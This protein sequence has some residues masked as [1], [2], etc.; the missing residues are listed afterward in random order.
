MQC[1]LPS[2]HDA[3]DNHYIF[4]MYLT[5]FILYQHLI[6]DLTLKFIFLPICNLKVICFKYSQN[7]NEFF[8]TT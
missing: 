8:Q 7:W 3:H 1:I 4:K 5:Y 6:K 2:A